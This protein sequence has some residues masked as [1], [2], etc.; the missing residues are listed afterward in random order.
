M[1]GAHPGIISQ[2]GLSRNARGLEKALNT[3]VE[4]NPFRKGPDEGA[5]NP[6][7]VATDSALDGVNGRFFV[8]RK[9][10]TAPDHTRSTERREALWDRTAKLV[11]MEP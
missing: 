1:N 6:V 7:W 11:G 3:M 10:V 9:E 5:D 4:L 8:D 2:T